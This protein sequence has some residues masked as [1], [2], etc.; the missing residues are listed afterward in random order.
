MTHCGPTLS[1]TTLSYNPEG[2]EIVSG[3]STLSD[4]LRTHS[5]SVVM[6]VHGHTHDGFGYRWVNNINVVNAG[7][8]VFGRF[9]TVELLRRSAGWSIGNVKLISV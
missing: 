3:S 2:V 8:L 1:T 6:N 9:T 5:K 4:F 7:P